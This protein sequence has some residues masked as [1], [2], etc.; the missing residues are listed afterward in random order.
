[1]SMR[2]LREKNVYMQNPFTVVDPT[3]HVTKILNM[4]DGENFLFPVGL[5]SK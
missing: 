3:K 5:K 1:M 2:K 4:N